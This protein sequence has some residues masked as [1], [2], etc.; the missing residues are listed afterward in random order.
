MFTGV[1]K[2]KTVQSLSQSSN[3]LVDKQV[4]TSR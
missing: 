4:L 2:L 3:P 1:F